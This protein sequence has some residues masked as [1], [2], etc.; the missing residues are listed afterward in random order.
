M[1]RGKVWFVG[2]GPGAADL[3]TLRG[4]RIISEADVVIWAASLVHPEILDYARPDAEVL[5]S[6]RLSLEQILARYADAAERGENVARVHSGDPSLYGAIQEQ[7][8]AL[9]RLR[10]DWEI[11]PGVSSLGATAAVLGRELTIPEVAQSLIITRLATSTPMPPGEQ[12]S[13]F[14]RHGTTMALFLSASRPRR[15]QDELLNG[16]YPPDTPCAVVYRASWPDQRVLRCL[17][18]ELATAIRGARLHQHALVLVGPALV[19]GG[20]RSHLY[21]PDFSHQHRQGGAG[22]RAA[23]MTG[24]IP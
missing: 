7:I 16:G 10:L 11:V 20:T 1:K 22:A 4:A 19:A 3:I 17:L 24:M 21:S 15:L 8:D 9:H 14:A 18:S 13:S 23:E 12:L 6:S 2:A 5:D